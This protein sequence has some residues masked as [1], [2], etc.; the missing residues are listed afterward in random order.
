MF[1]FVLIKKRTLMKHQVCINN[2]NRTNPRITVLSLLCILLFSSTHFAQKLNDTQDIGVF[3][4]DEEVIDYGTIAQNDN[5]MRTFKFTN[6]GRTPIVISKVKT[7]CGCTVPNYPKQ[8]IMPGESGT[9][10]ITYATNRIGVFSKSI[11]VISNANERNK[12]LR[13]KGNVV[14][15][16]KVTVN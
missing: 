12:T 4:F 3:H 10:D 2:R 13:I 7:S 11:T 5:G 8:S 6:K 15:K 14:V 16:P 9:I 1:V